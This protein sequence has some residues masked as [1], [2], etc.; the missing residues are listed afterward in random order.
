[1][2][3]VRTKIKKT[4]KLALLN[5]TTLSEFIYYIYSRLINTN[6]CDIIQLELLQAFN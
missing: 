5:F 1:M 4:L 2:R 3:Y 6:P